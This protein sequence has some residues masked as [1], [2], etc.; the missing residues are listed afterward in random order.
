MKR[1][2]SSIVCGWC[3]RYPNKINEEVLQR[4][5][6]SWHAYTAFADVQREDEVSCGDH[7]NRI[8]I[9]KHEQIIRSLYLQLQIWMQL[10]KKSNICCVIR[11]RIRPRDTP[12]D[13]TSCVNEH[14]NIVAYYRPC[15]K[16]VKITTYAGACIHNHVRFSLEMSPSM[17]HNP[18][19]H[20]KK[21]CTL[22]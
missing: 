8:E 14:K 11:N 7:S 19:G 17:V 21:Q 9:E 2:A 6:K 4:R 22:K 1:F 18:L 13:A 12:H 16:K 15:G 5:R 20:E 3:G 10:Y